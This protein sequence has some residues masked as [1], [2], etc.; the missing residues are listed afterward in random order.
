MRRSAV[1][2]VLAVAALTLSGTAAAL[3]VP[4][5]G[6]AGVTLGMKRLQVRAVLGTPSRVIH[7][8]NDFGA[9]TEFRYA[10]RALRLV[11]QGN[12]GLTAISTSATRE[13][14][15]RD[16]GVGSTEAQVRRG[17][18][19]VRCEGTPAMRHCYVGAFLAGRR[20]T[21]FWIRSGRV[22]RVVVGFVID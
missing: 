9:Y 20:V 19:G 6:M 21:D 3:L 14:T 7:G 22:S 10:P 4:Q 15:A 13:R 16:I 18:A 8:T 2:C 17:V 11:F 12:A 5:R 1:L